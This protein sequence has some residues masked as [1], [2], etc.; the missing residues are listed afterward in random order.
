LFYCLVEFAHPVKNAYP[1]AIKLLNIWQGVCLVSI[2]DGGVIAAGA[3]VT[4]IKVTFD[5]AK[6]E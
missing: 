1:L 6:H 5:L 4:N 3:V 2:G